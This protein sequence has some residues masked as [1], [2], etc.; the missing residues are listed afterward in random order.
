MC[1]YEIKLIT[2]GRKVLMVSGLKKIRVVQCLLLF[3]GEVTQTEG[4]INST[5]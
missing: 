1:T 2:K 5:V 4:R 3:Y